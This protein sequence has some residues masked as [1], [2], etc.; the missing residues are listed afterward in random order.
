MNMETMNWKKP[1]EEGVRQL[2]VVSLSKALNPPNSCSEANRARSV[3][4]GSSGVCVCVSSFLQCV[5]LNKE[6]LL[7]QVICA[8]WTVS[9]ILIGHNTCS[10]LPVFIISFSLCNE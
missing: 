3:D 4:Q 5:A 7:F 10:L 9:E 1:E 8:G 6:K 2:P